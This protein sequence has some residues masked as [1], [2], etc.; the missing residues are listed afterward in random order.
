MRLRMAVTILFL[1]TTA[2]GGGSQPAPSHADSIL[3]LKRRSTSWSYS[4]EGKSS[5]PIR[6]PWVP[7]G[8]LPRSVRVTLARL[9][10]TT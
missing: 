8:W 7:A 1:L 3:I 6:L 9:R 10:D 5:E 2:L 4:R